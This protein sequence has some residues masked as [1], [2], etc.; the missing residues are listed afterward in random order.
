[1]TV[2]LHY[3][4]P[5]NIDEACLCIESAWQIRRLPMHHI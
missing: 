5:G 2:C 3:E 1:V 4:Q